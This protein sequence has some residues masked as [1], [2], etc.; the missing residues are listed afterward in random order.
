MTSPLPALVPELTVTDIARSRAFYCDLLGWQVIYERPEERFAMLGLGGARLMLDALSV[1]RNFDATLT[2][3]D[4]PFG[5]GMNLEIETPDIAPMLAAL[6][7]A[8]HPLHL[9]PEEAW[10]RT[11]A[12]ESGQRQFIVADPDG[13]LLRFVQ[14]LGTRPTGAPHAL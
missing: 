11:G 10:Y 12:H 4:R 2:P 3:G 1:G 14:S 7:R 8:D 13:Y 6:A 5:R 9:P